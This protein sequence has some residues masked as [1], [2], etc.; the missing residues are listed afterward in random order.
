VILLDLVLPDATG[1]QMCGTLRQNPQTHSTPII[2]MT[3]AA[4]LPRQQAIGY[5]MGADACMV[6]PLNLIEVGDRL[7]ALLGSTPRPREAP[8]NFPVKSDPATGPSKLVF[9]SYFEAL[10]DNPS[11]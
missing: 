8:A 5:L 11:K 9:V 1:Y 6:K 3:S 10:F 4:R 2:M 7:H